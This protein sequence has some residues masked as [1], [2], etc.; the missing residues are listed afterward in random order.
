VVSKPVYTGIFSGIGG[1]GRVARK[2]FI[3]PGG[4]PADGSG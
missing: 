4:A 1:E 2:V 3:S